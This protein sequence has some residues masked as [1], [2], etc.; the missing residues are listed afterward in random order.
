M[1]IAEVCVNV[2]TNT[3][4]KNFTYAVPEKFK[5]LSAGWRVIIPFGRQKLDGFVINVRTIDDTAEFDFAL[6]EIIDVIDE[7]AWFTPVMM[8][9]ARWLAEF[10][11]CPLA[12]AMGLFMPGRRGRKLKIIYEKIIK[13]VG[14]FDEKEFSRAKTQLKLLQLLSERGTM[15]ATELAAEKIS[16][17]IVNALAEKNLVEIIKRRILRNSYSHVKSVAMTFDLTDEQRAA[18]ATVKNSLTQKKFRGFLL[19]GVTGSGKTQVYIELAKITRQLGRRVIILVPEIALTSQTVANFKA[20]FDDVAV[21]HS[22]LSI[23]ERADVFDKIRGEEIGT[24]IGARS[25]LFTPIDNVGLIVVD[26]EQ[27]SSY[28]Q[29]KNSPRYNAGTVAEEF[30]KFHDAVIVFGSAT[31]SLEKFYRA[32]QG[33]LTLLKMPHRVLNNPLPQIKCVDMRGE[34]R[35]GNFGVLSRE[36]IELLKKTV[37]DGQQAILLLNRRGWSTVVMCRSCGATAACPDCKMPMTYHADGKLRCHHC[38]IESE[39]PKICP[40]CK[41]HKIKFLGSGTEK[42]E[43]AL[44]TSLPNARV[45]RMDRDSTGGKFGHKKILEAFAAHEYDILFGTQMVA[46]G[47][48]IGGVTAVGVLSA[49]AALTFSNFR[50]AET[51]FELITQAAGRAGRANLPGKVIVQAYNVDAPA[52]R[53]GCNHDYEK[54]YEYELPQR[55]EIFFPPF[56]RLIKLIVTG[57]NEDKT[58]ARA[59]EIV[60]TFKAEVVGKISG[61]HEIFGPIPAAIAQLRDM[62]RFTVLIKTD[63]LSVVRRFLREHELHLRDDIQ[64]DIDPTTTD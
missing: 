16:S 42:L 36:L 4:D 61:R 1:I 9:E 29:E 48:D 17:T 31:P 15:T 22:K 20:H 27:D 18:I 63:N 57:R 64:I 46:R 26:E 39:P 25:A 2:T 3:I 49:D 10:Y 45:L 7:E 12:Q 21:I 52:V 5:T 60:K 35:E 23:D 47:H 51:C 13:L 44:K 6:K 19:H 59:V 54:F 55:K 11:L 58:V 24:M 28:K 40:V 53:F 8:S 56:C 37:A 41:S 33:E 43:H 30:A 62:F 32:Q 34:L 38:G 50:A 14:A